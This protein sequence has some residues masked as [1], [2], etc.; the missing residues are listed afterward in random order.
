MNLDTYFKNVQGLGVLSTA[1]AEG[2]VNAAVYARPHIMDDGSVAFI[3]R[4][5][6]THHNLQSNA[7]AAF[8]FREA[9]NG[10][11]GIRLHLTK[12]HAETDTER[13]KTLC[14]RCKIKGDPDETRHL[15]IFSVDRQ[16]ALIGADGPF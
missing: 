1:D 8:L 13:V 2:R 12:T 15:V 5:R 10:Y 14:R 7:H 9:G 11:K 3:M 4:D 6:L 16:L